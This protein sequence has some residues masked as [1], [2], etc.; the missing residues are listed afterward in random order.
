MKK[1]VLALLTI[2]LISGCT[3]A[4]EYA[5]VPSMDQEWKVGYQ[6]REKFT[7]SN[8][9]E[10]IPPNETIENWSKLFTIQYVAGANPNLENFV[11]AQMNNTK[12]KCADL[13]WSVIEQSNNSFLYEW[14]TKSCSGNN[15][16]IYTAQH[17]ITRHINGN[18]GMHIVSY[19]EKT[20]NI[21]EATR[22][23]WIERLK[24]ANIRKNGEVVN[25]L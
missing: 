1:L 22:S 17:V 2:A 23:Q 21:S 9:T 20:K 24:K 5:I 11:T 13:T 12:K 16:N 4:L 6:N 19:A 8:I 25:V 15:S 3:A 18:D 7:N 14:N 10:F